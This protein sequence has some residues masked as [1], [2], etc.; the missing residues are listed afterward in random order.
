MDPA[1][2][3]FPPRQ[4]GIAT[5]AG[6]N[7]HIAAR[8]LEQPADRVS[9]KTLARRQHEAV[10][11]V[12]A[13]RR[14]TRP[15]TEEAFSR[16]QP[17]GASPIQQRRSPHR[18]QPGEARQGNSQKPPSLE[19]VDHAACGGEPDRVVEF[20][21]YLSEKLGPEV[22]WGVGRQKSASGNPRDAAT[23]IDRPQVANAIS[24]HHR[25]RRR[26]LVALDEYPVGWCIGA[27]LGEL[28]AHRRRHDS[29][30]APLE[31]RTHVVVG[32]TIRKG[33]AQQACPGAGSIE[34]AAGTVARQDGDRN[35]DRPRPGA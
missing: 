9:R 28:A 14:V 24:P 11:G 10:E 33:H 27:E 8:I 23:L 31:H 19:S 25:R 1:G 18:R 4:A 17:D 22:G 3:A 12:G 30:I 6:G 5:G 7:P 21:N 15:E 16:P 29:S 26:S 34:R 32:R 20:A 2:R 35:R 13:I